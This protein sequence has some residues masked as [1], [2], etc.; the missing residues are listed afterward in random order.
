MGFKQILTG[1]VAYSLSFGLASAQEVPPVKGVVELFTS[2]GC[3]SCPPA[4]RAFEN[5]VGQPGIVALAYHVDYWNYR[6]WAD[7]LGSPGNTARQYG[8]ARSFGRNGVYTPQAVVN[9]RVQMKATDPN[10]VSGKVSNLMS[11]GDG[12]KVKV[13]A[14]LKGDELAINVGPGEGKADVVVVY[15]KR[16]KDVDVLKGENKGQR[17]TYWNSVTD[18]QSVGMWH[19]DQVSLTIPAKMMR[20]DSS[21]GVAVLLQSSTAKGDPSQILGATTVMTSAAASN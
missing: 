14:A 6:G 4:D 20:D 2:Q 9:G 5:L 16:R 21:D 12:L 10:A 19:G 3:N 1:L 17:F 13:N 11:S 8:Y 18:I 15:F 7:T